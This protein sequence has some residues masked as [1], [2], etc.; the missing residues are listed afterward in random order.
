MM[1]ERALKFEYEEIEAYVRE[2]YSEAAQT[3]M[4][5][6]ESGD[7]S[8]ELYYSGMSAILEHLIDTYDAEEDSDDE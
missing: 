7:L 4:E 5:C 2:L 3:V 1:L 6:R 8:G